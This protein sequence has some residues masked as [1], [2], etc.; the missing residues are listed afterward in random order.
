MKFDCRCATWR[1]EQRIGIGYDPESGE[2]VPVAE[3]TDRLEGQARSNLTGSLARLFG[4]CPAG[5]LDTH[6]GEFRLDQT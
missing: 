5:T 2:T 6:E 4:H 1:D 3:F